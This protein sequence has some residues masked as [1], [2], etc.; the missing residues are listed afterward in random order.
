MSFHVNVLL[1]VSG[2][3]GLGVVAQTQVCADEDVGLKRDGFLGGFEVEG[4]PR[5]GVHHR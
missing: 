3:W 1:S 5:L 4:G 2:L